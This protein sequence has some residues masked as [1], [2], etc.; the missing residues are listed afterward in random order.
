ML[1]GYINILTAQKQVQGIKFPEKIGKDEKLL[2]LNGAGV[3]TKT[4]IKVYVAGL[5]LHSKSTNPQEIINAD[6]PMAVRLQITSSLVTQDRMA[7][8]IIEGFEKSTGGKTKSI[9]KEIDMIV[10]I[11]KSD[12]IKIGDIFDIWYIPG[13]GV[14]A[15]KNNKK[16]DF[17]IAG[18]EFKKVLFGI[19]LGNNPVEISLKNKM[20]GL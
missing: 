18:F 14:M 9:R 8:A 5:Y 7:D 12:V 1:I 19:W 15:S 3:R 20:L 11:F 10:N 17:M 16:Y 2:Y 6:E 13:K 4:F